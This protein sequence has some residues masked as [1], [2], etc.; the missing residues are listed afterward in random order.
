M[1]IHGFIDGALAVIVLG[2]AAL[3]AVAVIYSR[4]KK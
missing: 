3:I 2:I 4:K 1:Y